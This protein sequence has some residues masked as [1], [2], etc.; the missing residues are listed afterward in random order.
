MTAD[1]HR[2]VDTPT[3]REA[4]ICHGT[5]GRED[6]RQDIRFKPADKH[7]D[8]T[9]SHTCIPGITSE[10]RETLQTSKTR[11]HVRART[12]LFSLS[13]AS[14][15][16]ERRSSLQARGLLLVAAAG[17]DP[18]AATAQTSEAV[19]GPSE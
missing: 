4:A 17:L 3:S 14:N 10:V 15:F 8:T 5:R 19:P 2:I 9:D 18:A 6:A 13:S 12:E 16:I 11:A 7:S 1:R